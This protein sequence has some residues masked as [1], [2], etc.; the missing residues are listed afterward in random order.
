MRHLVQDIGVLRKKRCLSFLRGFEG[1]QQ[2]NSCSVLLRQW[3]RSIA[4]I[5]VGQKRSLREGE[6]DKQ[7]R[8]KQFI[9]RMGRNHLDESTEYRILQVKRPGKDGAEKKPSRSFRSN[10]TAKD[11]H[12]DVDRNL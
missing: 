5:Q 9:I 4:R 2:F 12:G 3:M 1:S 7:K 10:Q 6:I 11:E 8:V